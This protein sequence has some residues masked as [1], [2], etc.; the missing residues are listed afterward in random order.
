MAKPILHIGNMNYS[1]WSMRPWLALKW[2]G[3]EFET[4]VIPLGGEGYRRQQIPAITA[5]SPS[6]RVPVL[7]V[8]GLVIHDSLAICEWAAEQNPGLWPKDAGARALARAAAAEM[9]SGFPYIRRDMSMN[10]RRRLEKEPAWP[11]E[12][13]AELVRL[14][15]LWEGML[16][17]FGGPFLGGGRSN[18]DAMYAP[19]VTRLRTYAVSLPDVV[20]A[21]SDAILA[22]AAFKEWEA[23]ALKEIWTIADADALYT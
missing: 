17:R 9:H 11:E 12:T 15:T 19:V 16:E 5:V 23:G 6:G 8:D 22:D 20:R 21:Y 13:H 3:I 2:A 7:H 10:I 18:V 14:F 4:R 1:S